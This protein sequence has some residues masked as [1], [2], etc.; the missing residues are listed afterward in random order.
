MANVNG[1]IAEAVRGRDGADQRG[2]DDALIALDLDGTDGKRRLG[3]NAIL[4]VSMAVARP[5]ARARQAAALGAISAATTRTC[6]RC[7]R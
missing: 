5:P 3:A 2:L 1:E 7:R 6:S 4:G